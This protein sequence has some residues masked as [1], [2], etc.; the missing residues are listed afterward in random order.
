MIQPDTLRQDTCATG[1]VLVADDDPSLLVLAQAALEPDGHTVAV[2]ENGEE[3]CR[4]FDEQNPDLVLLDVGMPRLDGFGV[5]RR[6]R[7]S[8][9]G[10]LTPVVMLT[11]LDDNESV[12]R[13]F[14][15]GATDFQT[16][17]VDWRVLRE[18]IKCML[19]AKRDADELAKLAH[20][21]SLTG[22]PNRVTFQRQLKRRLVLAE[23]RG[24]LLAV[25][26]L[27]LDG[28]KEINDA[29]GHEFGDQILK[30]AAQRL[31]HGLRAGDELGH[32]GRPE[33]TVVAGRFGGDEFTVLVSDM[34]DVAAATAVAD[35]V[36]AAFASPFYVEGREV[37]VTTSTGVSI[38]PFDGTDAETLMKHA[39][40]AMYEAKTLG[41][42]NHA[43]YRPA[44]SA[45]ASERLTL[46]AEL[47]RAVAHEEFRM[48]FQPKVEI[49]S[50]CVVGAEA[51]I[52]WQHS[53]RGLLGAIGV[54]GARGGNR[55]GSADW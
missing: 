12:A 55:P 38:Y 26:F 46:A 3:A 14:E 41:R 8:T 49:Q 4:L 35:R 28:F 30:H 43:P 31:A 37:F 39:D 18:R 53:E 51:L 19:K 5:L 45:K 36:R 40:A 50:G 54:H 2:A 34:P 44:M 15:V 32:P 47:R 17:P 33:P 6:L 22:L 29:F 24:R 11:A 52:R 21:D 13:A 16:K 25:L 27:D 42:N 1:S 48:Y 9:G 7:D 20:Y 10:E 23:E